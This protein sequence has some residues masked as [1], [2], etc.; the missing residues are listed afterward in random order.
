M[1][2]DLKFVLVLIFSFYTT[3]LASVTVFAADLIEPQKNN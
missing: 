2:H 1:R 3:A